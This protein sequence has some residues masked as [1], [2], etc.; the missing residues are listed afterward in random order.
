MKNLFKKTYLNCS[1]LVTG[2]TGFKGSWLVYWLEKMGAN[3]VGYSINNPSDPNH[4]ELLQSNVISISGDILDQKHLDQIVAKYKPEIVF[5]LAAQS[6]VKTSY[7]NPTLTFETNV[8]GT[9]KVF[10]SCRKSSSVKA[11]INVTSD[12]C[13]QNKEWVWGYREND[14]FGGHDPY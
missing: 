10:E 11:I 1:V 4:F 8:L 7:E 13:Y 5:H 6:L 9:L 12:K 3:V 2:H 14:P